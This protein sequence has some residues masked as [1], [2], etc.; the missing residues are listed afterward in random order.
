MTLT[1]HKLS[2]LCRSPKGFERAGAF[3]DD[4]AHGPLTSELSAH[5]GP[6]LDRLPAVVRLR[7][8]RVRLSI[9]SRHLGPG[10]LAEA[11][12][13]A[14]AIAL[15]R[16]LAYPESD[17][18]YALRRYESE[19]AYK[20]AMLHYIVTQ[21]LA[22]CWQFPELHEWHNCS[23]AQAAL[24][25]LLDPPELAIETLAQMASKSWLESLLAWWDEHSLEQVV[26]AVAKAE[27]GSPGLS[28]ANLIEVGLAA[29]ASG[30]LLS[31]W[32]ISSRR[33]AVRLWLRLSRRLPLRG[34]WQ[35]LRL[36]T[37]LLETPVVL[38][39]SI[40]A[41]LADPIPF[42][43][44]CEAILKEVMGADHAASPARK[45]LEGVAPLLDGR[46]AGSSLSVVL[47]NLRPLVP[48]SA[49]AGETGKWTPSDCAGVLL[50]LSIAR[51]L[52]FWRLAREAEFV[53]FGGC[54][55]L[56]FLLA[57]V[58]MTLLGEWSP[59]NPIEPAVALFA[60]IFAEPDRAGMRQF[61]AESAVRAISDLVKAETWPEALAAAAAELARAF[62]QR[63]RGFRQTSREAV[64][65]Q[66][67]RV[68]GRVLV[69]DRRL[70]VV[71]DPNPWSVAL[72][73]SG[74]DETLDAVQW[75]GDRR[76]EFVLEGL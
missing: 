53:R 30:G 38:P 33:Q 46:S 4:V 74:V 36:L 27:T 25:L 13:R 26:Y 16:A 72:H 71:L 40:G 37:R 5:L 61:F 62:A 34:V 45:G 66:F 51:R 39:R 42:P 43:D 67:L 35:G 22:P 8:L 54:R 10:L 18:T 69:E 28:L 58:G 11:W 68:P 50:L 3:V 15:H 20:A 2:T 64:V 56:S 32:S 55:A 57:G 60:G 17:G 19:A 76:V 23:A 7:N 63:I 59:G 65:R 47:E 52:G 14:F 31:Q 75:M 48:S 70:L 44:W 6:S 73:I 49:S 1:I 29:A 21:G 24:G 9:P 12:A 41:W